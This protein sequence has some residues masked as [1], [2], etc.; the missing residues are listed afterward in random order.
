MTVATGDT[1]DTQVEVEAGC[2]TGI[3]RYKSRGLY[4]PVYSTY[5]P[6]SRRVE[7]MPASH[8]GDIPVGA[9]PLAAF[10]GR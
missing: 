1:E 5:G 10:S 3:Y 9:L 8:C 4:Q 7:I 2:H 6:L